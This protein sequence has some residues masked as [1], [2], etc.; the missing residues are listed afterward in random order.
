[1]QNK[2]EKTMGKKH[3]KYQFWDGFGEGFGRGLGG[4]GQTKKELKKRL[5]KEG[6]VGQSGPGEGVRPADRGGPR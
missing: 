3:Q 2:G 1:M 5:K 6:G 4:F